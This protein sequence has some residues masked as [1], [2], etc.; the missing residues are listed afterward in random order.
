MEN[1]NTKKNQDHIDRSLMKIDSCLRNGQF[2]YAHRESNKLMAELSRKEY[3][4]STETCDLLK[5]SIKRTILF[6]KPMIEPYSQNQ[7]SIGIIRK[8]VECVNKKQK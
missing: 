7:K 2:V 6:L 8:A 3:D 5:D 4:I 1:L